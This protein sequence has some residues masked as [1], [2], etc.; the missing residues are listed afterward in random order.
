MLVHT[1]TVDLEEMLRYY[2]IRKTSGHPRDTRGGNINEI[3]SPF[4]THHQRPYQQCNF[5]SLF[6]TTYFL[7]ILHNFSYM[8]FVCILGLE[9]MFLLIGK[10][11]PDAEKL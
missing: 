1:C 3:G 10:I 4:A 11:M 5:F 8:N 7:A 9:Y 2:A 6:S